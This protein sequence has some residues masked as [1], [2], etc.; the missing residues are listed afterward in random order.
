MQ[1]MYFPF[2]FNNCLG[3]KKV[4]DVPKLSQLMGESHYGFKFLFALEDGCV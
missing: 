4:I 1:L 2:V 3:G